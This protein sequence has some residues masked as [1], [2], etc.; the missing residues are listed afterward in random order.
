MAYTEKS[1][2]I[3]EVTTSIFNALIIAEGLNPECGYA[4]LL[5]IAEDLARDTVRG[6]LVVAGPL[7]TNNPHTIVPKF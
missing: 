3:C 5:A 7:G 2:I 1:K 4:D 6:S